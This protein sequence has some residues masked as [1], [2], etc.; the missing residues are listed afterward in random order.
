MGSFYFKKFAIRHTDSAMKVNTDG[1]LLPAWVSVPA[2]TS[3]RYRV[4][5]IGTGTGVISLII[6]QRL[7]ETGRNSFEITAIDI[8][9]DAVKEAEYN[10]NNSPWKR[11]LKSEHI[12]LQDFLIR[13]RSSQSNLLKINSVESGS[14]DNISGSTT[15]PDH[16]F[17][18]VKT[19]F[20]LII[21]N[22]PFFSN[23]LL[24][25]SQRRSD[26]RH[27]NALPFSDLLK[28]ASDLLE[29]DGVFAVV[30]PADQGG[31]VIELAKENG[32]SPL[33]LCRVKT[34][35]DKKE[36]RYL[37]EFSKNKKVSYSEETLVMQL[38]GGKY[39]TP[40]YCS[41]VENFYLKDF[42]R[43]SSGE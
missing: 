15:F 21:S 41:L 36:K 10:F 2:I 29:E 6:A 9:P 24:P 28:G 31:T 43:T 37:I 22:P 40:E 30:L 5:D 1:V 19:K 16:E 8:D 3:K 13:F 33:R 35:A 39:Y 12:S 26:A 25:P 23:S 38:N 7:A 27:N 34:L 11:V 17:E 4:L 20:S 14:S 32:L 42:P 18:A